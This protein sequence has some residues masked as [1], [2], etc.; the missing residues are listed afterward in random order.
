MVRLDGQQAGASLPAL[1]GLVPGHAVCF[2][3]RQCLYPQL[4]TEGDLTLNARKTPLPLVKLAGGALGVRRGGILQKPARRSWIALHI[5]TDPGPDMHSDLGP[6]H[7]CGPM[8]MAPMPSTVENS[9]ECRVARP[10]RRELP[11]KPLGAPRVRQGSEGGSRP[12]WDFSLPPTLPARVRA[13]PT[14]KCRDYCTHTYQCRASTR[15]CRVL[16][17]LLYSTTVHTEGNLTLHLVL[18]ALL[19][20]GSHALITPHSRAAVAHCRC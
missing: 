7:A 18:T 2:L 4:F 3:R 10:M 20:C 6:E 9:T 19:P 1:H 8:I 15:S 13:F 14:L 12:F 17:F 16:P 5:A 11:K